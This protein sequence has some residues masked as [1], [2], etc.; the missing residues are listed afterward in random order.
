MLIGIQ[1]TKSTSF[2]GV[3]QEFHNTYHYQLPTA[4]TVP[5]ETLIDQL[6]TTEKK[7]HSSQ[8]TFRRAAIWTAGGTKLE[9][10]MVYK[11]QLSGSGSGASS[12]SFDKERAVLFRWPAGFDTR[13]NPVYLRKWYHSCGNPTGTT[14]DTA[15][16]L[17]NTA[18]IPPA[19]RTLLETL[20][21]EVTE[22]G[23]GEFWDLCA[24]SGRDRQGLPSCHAYLEHHQLGDMWRV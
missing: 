22:L 12:A 19:T 20:A 23:I 18:V 21:N 3:E 24:A 6:L 1:M 15:G 10:S 2:R 14:I 9:N 17:Q 13:G 7:L 8:V 5:S 16:I 4:V 11:A